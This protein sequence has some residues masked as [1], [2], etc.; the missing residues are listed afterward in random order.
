MTTQ[1]KKLEHRRP[2]FKFGSK[3]PRHWLE[4]SPF[5]THFLNSLTLVFPSGEKYFIRSIQKLIAQIDSPQIKKDAQDFIRQ[6]AQH[7]LEH[8]KFF[9]ILQEQG[10]SAKEIHNCIDKII[11][12]ILEPLNSQ[13]FNLA[14]TAGLE[15]MTALVAQVGLENDFL[16]NAP[17][18]LKELFNW[19]AAE[20]IEHRSVAF[21]VY[22]SLS[23]DTL[24]R[25]IA[26]VYANVLLFLMISAPT[27]YLLAKDRELFKAA[28]LKDALDMFFIK[29]KLMLR[30]FGIFVDYLRPDFHPSQ[31]E[32]DEL[33]SGQFSK[34]RFQA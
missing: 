16:R 28:T 27:A 26:F 18:P 24:L 11:T 9:A 34:L 23:G 2:N 6:E 15:H 17:S 8:K 1:R 32:V 7:A 12:R 19:H 14:I 13:N 22:Q 5:K 33:A 30:A 29:D 3:I 20:E 25:I 10:Y 31:S 4:G 21:D